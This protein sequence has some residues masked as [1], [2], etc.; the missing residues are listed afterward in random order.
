MVF[1]GAREIGNLACCTASVKLVTK[2][3]LAREDVGSPRERTL[4][5]GLTELLQLQSHSSER[6]LL[7]D[8]G[9]IDPENTGRTLRFRVFLLPAVLGSD[10][11]RL[12]V[13]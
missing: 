4:G 9:K 6:Q 11:C 5:V 8:S 12:Q 10:L 1:A 3:L 7:A 2:P 13:R